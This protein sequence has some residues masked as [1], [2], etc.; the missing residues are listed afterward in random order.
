MYHSQTNGFNPQQAI[1][2]ESSE[3][4]TLGRS[5]DD[6][7]GNDNDTMEAP[8][9]SEDQDLDPAAAAARKRRYRRHTQSQIREMESFFKECPHPDDKQRKEL[10]RE[11]GL[12]PMQIK[13]WFQNKR[14]QVKTQHE[15]HENNLLKNEN[16]RL[17][18]E[19]IRFKDTLKT[20]VCPGCGS[21]TAVGEIT[22]MS[23]DEQRLRMEN[24]RLRDEIER[25]SAIAAKY[26]PKPLDA[27]CNMPARS[28]DMVVSGNY[29]AQADLGMVEEMDDENDPL[30]AFPLPTDAD[31]PTI[32]QF[33]LL[34][35]EEVTRLALSGEPLWIPGN[36][37]SETLN[38]AEYLRI[39]PRATAQTQ[40]CYKTE[41]SRQ[42]AVVSMNSVK[43][44]EM[45]MDVVSV[46]D[47]PGTPVK[48]QILVEDIDD[49]FQNQWANVFC[50]IVTR[51]M[52]LEV[53]STGVIS[54]YNGA[55]HV[56]AA[57][58]Q[59]PSPLVPTREHYFVRYSKKH[60]DE[61]WIIVDLPLDH[62]RPGAARGSQRRPSGCI[63]QELPNGFSKV[64]WVEHAEVD[65]REVHYL[66]RPFVNSGLAF[67]ATRWLATLDRQCERVVSLFAPN[68]PAGE[69]S[70]ITSHAG[71]KGIMKLAERMMT[72]FCN[73]VGASTAHVWTLLR[74]GAADLRV[75]TRKSVD[76]P[77]RP[78]GIVLSAATS[79][80]LPVTPMKVF[81][82]LRDE[83]MRNRWDILCN[84]AIVD[85]IAH[86]ANGRDAGNC[87]SLLR[88]NGPNTTQSNMIILQE[89]WSDAAG[90][91][92]AYAPVDAA[93]MNV[94]LDGGNPDYVALLPSGFAIL[95]DG[96]GLSNGPIIEPGTGGCLLTVAFQILVDSSPT[97]RITFG[98]ITTVN[99][100]IKCT[101]DRI[102]AAVTG[103]AA[104]N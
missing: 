104:P 14:T 34:A 11:L 103:V 2:V 40:L 22:E 102:T 98:S 101:V 26:A 45:L 56:M 12:D 86:I 16:D 84:G 62:L 28:L 92:V 87:V 73:G 99:N 19:N 81:D 61:S 42:S 50:G 91:Y 78:P 39:F 43:I 1:N 41:A 10:S 80:W 8:P 75:M 100:L 7:S 70:V 15:R 47:V 32:V 30:K 35:M 53:L 52:T 6:T 88:V 48:I 21:P 59:V 36:Y 76:D 58:F 44:V 64:I 20:A 55:L 25:F 97:A 3:S 77:G 63:I 23:L 65:D 66:Y 54:K 49:D 31:K 29:G 37:G 85:E 96:P 24:A 38:E 94:V 18:A 4:E 90:A 60:T 33:S 79:L 27:C 69:L 82:F 74:I 71:R 17:R 68:L 72:S 93:A 13:F 51:A 95:P 57:E 89:S 83:N 9:S 5:R 67:G 46:T